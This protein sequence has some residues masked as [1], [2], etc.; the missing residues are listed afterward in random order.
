MPDIQIKDLPLKTAAVSDKVA[1]QDAGDLTGYVPAADLLALAGVVA[2][3]FVAVNRTTGVGYASIQAAINAVDTGEEILV[4]SGNHTEDLITAA[5]AAKSNVKLVGFNGERGYGTNVFGSLTMSGDHSNWQVIGIRFQTNDLNKTALSD[6]GSK[7]VVF[8]HCTFRQDPG[9]PGTVPVISL[10]GYVT[11]DD[12]PKFHNCNINNDATVDS[13]EIRAD[14][15]EPTVLV[16]FDSC[17]GQADLTMKGLTGASIWQCDLANHI[18]HNAGNLIMNLVTVEQITSTADDLGGGFPLLAIQSTVVRNQTTYVHGIINKTGTCGYAITDTKFNIVGSTL[19][20]ADLSAAFGDMVR[21]HDV[22]VTDDLTVGGKVTS[23]TV[24]GAIDI[25]GAANGAGVGGAANVTGGDSGGASIG[26]A[27]VLTGGSGGATGV[28]GA[29]AA[30]GGVPGTDQI[31]GALTLAA[32]AGDGTAVGGAASLAGGAG[33]ATGAGGAASVV[34]GAGSGAADGGIGSLAGG[35]G[36]ATGNG[37]AATVAG[38]NGDDGGAASVTGGVADAGT[39]GA[40]SL[41]GGD[42]NWAGG[43]A[44]VI[45]GD[46]TVS[47]VGGAVEVTAGSSQGPSTGGALALNGGAGGGT[48]VG[49]AIAVTGGTGGTN[50]VGGNTDLTGGTGGGNGTGGAASVTGGTGGATGDGGAASVAGG[51]GVGGGDGG[52]VNL[53]GGAGATAGIVNSQSIH[54]FDESLLVDE[55]VEP[56]TGANQGALFV[57]DGSGGLTANEPYYRPASAATSQRLTEFRSEKLLVYD[58]NVSSGSSPLSCGVFAFNPLEWPE[59]SA[60]EIIATLKSE[61]AGITAS[62]I[63]YNLDDAEAVTFPGAISTTSTTFVKDSSG[64]LTVG[65]GAGNLRS[66]EKL[67]EIR[68]S[69]SGGGKTAYADNVVM[70]ITR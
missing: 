2:G 47:G 59:G 55:A 58:R 17:Y 15:T 35:A 29:V 12:P 24:G 44:S 56:T 40:A 57:S 27:V 43:P 67:Y 36:G 11:T 25:E 7:N 54:K 70:S 49:G 48:G 26:G 45:A 4:K 1:I 9:V 6:T 63:L 38:G 33:G 62:M 30:T 13:I 64:A 60:F 41:N 34:A 65:A 53:A 42:G 3:T 46:A 18:T 50:K 32:G 69:S 10:G 51:A 52:D 8:D 19:T 16:Q 14:A 66:S 68:L 39:G 20:G 21:F 5:V 22:S 31:G 28:G 23:P 61:D 37:G